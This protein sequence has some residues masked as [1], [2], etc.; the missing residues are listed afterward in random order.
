MERPTSVT[1]FGVLNIIFGAL[2][3]LGTIV[4]LAMFAVPVD[5]R[6]PVMKLMHE[7]GPYR[8]WLMLCIPIGVAAGAVELAAGIGMLKLR[9]WGRMLS[10][11]YSIFSI[12]FC[13]LNG[14]VTYLYLMRPLM[15]QAAQQS[16]PEA[17]GAFAGAMGGTIGGCVGLI[18]PV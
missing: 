5:E 16:G 1:V 10:V 7:N 8:A 13:I 4:S 14:F 17:A 2:A 11:G 18:Y 3:V 6:N 15:A 9:P 12:V